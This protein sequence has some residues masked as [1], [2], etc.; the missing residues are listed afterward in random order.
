MHR[1]ERN[2]WTKFEY[3]APDG[4][5]LAGRQYGWQHRERPVVV[6]LA[7]LSRNSADFHELALHLAGDADCPRAVLAL[8]YRGR[9]M[10]AH[11]PDPRN[12]NPL[13]EA[14]DTIAGMT[15]AGIGHASFV[16]TSRGGLIA[17]ILSAMR[18][19]AI[20]AVVMNDIGPRIGAKGLLRIRSYLT[21]DQEFANWSS[22]VRFLRAA[23]EAQFPAFGDSDWERQ[24]RTIFEERDGRIHRRYDPN[25]LRAF[26]NMRFDHTLPQMWPQFR[27]LLGVPVMAIRGENSDLLDAETLQEM[28]R[29]HPDLETVTVEG[30]GHAPDLATGDLPACISAFLARAEKRHRPS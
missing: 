25:L 11:D 4:L 27:G 14:E 1:Q 9:G 29:M 6:C 2:G 18:P 10:S 12:Y 26:A 20:G 30:Q 16:A 15:A 8:D 3:S 23:G 17:M 21:A 5:R 24:A 22:A 13:T 7:G 19:S 28:A